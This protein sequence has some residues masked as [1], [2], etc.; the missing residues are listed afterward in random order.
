MRSES[1]QRGRVR[2]VAETVNRVRRLAPDAALRVRADARFFSWDLI[3]QLNTRPVAGH[4]PHRPHTTG[5]SGLDTGKR[6]CS[7]E[8]WSA[9]LRQSAPTA[10]AARPAR[11]LLGLGTQV[12]VDV[13]GDPL[14]VL[15]E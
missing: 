4:Q 15:A 1:S 7:R 12:T 2:F 5:E 11:G 3:E 14:K 8:G 10:T 13:A 6:T 9:G